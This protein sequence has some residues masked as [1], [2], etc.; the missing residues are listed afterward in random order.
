MT[1]IQAT[2]DRIRSAHPDV[3]VYLTPQPAALE[4]APQ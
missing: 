3:K 1:D 2:M 4:A